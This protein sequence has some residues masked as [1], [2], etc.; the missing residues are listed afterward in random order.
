VESVPHR[1]TR[2][3]HYDTLQ[4]P[5][6]PTLGSVPII[7]H[8]FS[9]LFR[10][11]G[12]RTWVFPSFSFIL[13]YA[14]GGGG[15]LSQI[16][17]GIAVAS[18]VTAATNIINAYADRKEDATNQP[19]RLFWLGQIGSRHITA[20]LVVLY[21]SAVALAVYL[22]P[23]FMLVLGIGILNSVFYSLPPLRFKAKP[24][25]S[26][27][28]FSGALGLPF[29]G[30]LGVRGSLDLLNPMLWLLTWFMFT[31]GTVKNLPDYFGDMKAGIRTS[32]TV[33]KNVKMAVLF[34]CTLLSTP[35]ILLVAFLSLGLLE[36]IYIADFALIP[37]FAFII[38]EMLRAK[39]PAGLEKAHTLGFFY[40]ISFLLF[41]LVLTSP[42]IQSLVMVLVA[43][44]WTL[45]V[46]KVSVHSRVESRDW[47]KQKRKTL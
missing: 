38:I 32:A 16:G 25:A 37:L 14:V 10:L 18:L 35:F 4:G 23:L 6:L 24:F 47:E 26:L 3:K 44:L 46:A 1:K 33:F 31:Y 17:I 2:N 12:P 7:P 36:P 29:L 5:S 19:Q 40:A 9:I 11:S 42:T 34:S 39:D 8:T 22:G 43:Y 45:T 20:S 21:S 41:T 30:G 28:S 27:A 13:G 15:Q